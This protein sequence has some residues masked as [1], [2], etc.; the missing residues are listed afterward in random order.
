MSYFELMKQN[1]RC[2]ADECG[3]RFHY[4]F[5]NFFGLRD[6]IH[7]LGY[8]RR[9]LFVQSLSSVQ[10]PKLTNALVLEGLERNFNGTEDFDSICAHFIKVS[11][12]V[13]CFLSY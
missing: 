3:Q 1:E 6:F 10:F 5:H 12:L 13:M 11:I 7:F 2:D 9:K 4:P 8:L